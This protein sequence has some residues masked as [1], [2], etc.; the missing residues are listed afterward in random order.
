MPY[1]SDTI[2]NVVSR[3][4]VQYFLPA[5]QREFVWKPE[6]T[7]LLFDSLMQRY[8]ISSFLFWELKPENRDKWDI[9]RFIT[10]YR[11][12][13]THNEMTGATGVQQLTL[14]LDGQQRLTSLLIG[15]KGTYTIKKKHLRYDNPAA[16]VK[17]SLYIDLLTEPSEEAGIDGYRFVFAENLP[18]NGSSHYWFKVGRILDFDSEA[19]FEEFCSQEEDKL[20]ESATKAQV[21][22]FRRNLARLYQVF[23]KDQIIS[24]YVEY[25]QDYDRVLDIF[26]RAN[27]GGTK[28]SKSDLLL[29]MVTAS[30]G[31]ANAREE[32]FGF[33]DRLNKELD[34]K[35]DLDKDFVLKTCLALC[36]LPVQYRVENFKPQNLALIQSK[37]DAIKKAIESA[38]RLVNSFGL[39]RD[40]L[41]SANA[42]I[43]IAYFL[44]RNP[45]LKLLGGTSP[46]DVKN[47]S[48]IRTWLTMALLN[49]VFGGTSDNILQDI[50][51]VIQTQPSSSTD[52]PAEAINAEIQRQGRTGRFDDQAIANF[53]EISYGKQGSFLALSLLYDDNAWGSMVFHEDH[54]FPKSLFTDKRLEENGIPAEKRK[55]YK[56][57][58]NNIGNL[59]LLLHAE[60]LEKSDKPFLNWLATRDQGFRKR[61][62]IPADDTML[63]LDQFEEFIAAREALI[64]ERLESLFASKGG[65]QAA[66]NLAAAVHETSEF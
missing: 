46:A 60:N 63:T 11:Q 56:E 29:S 12:G 4:N 61:H 54:I 42:L 32:I 5:I 27:E 7:I 39:D 20:P 30:W 55:A 48:A 35:N 62:H 33:V 52:F 14:V 22:I 24:Y 1:Q 47:A 6:Q 43:P 2:A 59:Q 21:R 58:V 31:N 18:E 45:G 49:G 38:V 37:W 28:L 23:W 34:R 57:L 65:S 13:G 26:V 53:L 50:R 17:Q 8:P 40:T 66:G 41:T 44:Y 19:A 9:Y 15:L 3:L 36:D 51:R 64:R 25:N 10:N 16:W